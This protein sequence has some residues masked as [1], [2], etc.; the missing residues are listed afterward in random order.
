[1]ARRRRRRSFGAVA[2]H[3]SE[4][5]RRSH[6]HKFR[7]WVYVTRDIGASAA[8]QYKAEACIAKRGHN[9]KPSRCALGFGRTP[10]AASKKALRR[11]ASQVK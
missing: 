9:P 8:H 6:V 5:T 11:I 7:L 3:G 2:R 4:Y 1:M 10:T